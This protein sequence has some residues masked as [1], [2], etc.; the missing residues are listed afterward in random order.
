VH[1]GYK[2]KPSRS[3]CFLECWS[4]AAFN[5]Q[6]GAWMSI[7]FKNLAS[8]AKAAF[9]ARTMTAAK[10]IA[11]EKEVRS[12]V[13]NDAVHKL[14]SKILPT[15]EM[16]KAEFQHTGV[17]ARISN[18]FDVESNSTKFPSII[19]QC[20]GPARADGYQFPTLPAFFESDGKTFSVGLGKL[21]SD[22]T[23]KRSLG[24]SPPS[25]IDAL[26][27][28]AA[29]EV[30]ESYYIELAKPRSTGTP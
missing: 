22:R 17:E 1:L 10:K 5:Q 2:I 11:D 21:S 9:D 8:Q 28:Q 20:F 14:R 18:D 7:D 15:L 12:K 23:A 24:T 26:V 13:L 4:V 19:F 25:D 16:A 29:R 6:S 27:E 30:I 3:Q